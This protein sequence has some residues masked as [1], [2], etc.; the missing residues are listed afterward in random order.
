M[1]AD[2][3]A[4][5]DDGAQRDDLAAIR[6]N[7]G[8]VA[9][10]GQDLG[11]ARV[12]VNLHA[13]LARELLQRDRH[14]ARATHRI[15]DALVG[16]HVRDAAEHGRRTVRRR[17]DVLREVIHHL[18]HARIRRERAHRSRDAAPHAHGKH[19]AEHLGIEGGFEI[20]HV[21]QATNGL[22][23]EETLRD[24]VQP[25]A[26]LEEV[27]VTLAG[28]F[29]GRKTLE[30]S[31]HLFRLL[32]QVQHRAILK[33]AAPLRV[34]PDHVE[35]ILHAT[36]GLGEDAAQ[37]R[38]NRHNGRAHVEAEAVALELRSLATEPFVSFEEDDLVAASGE[39]AGGG[40]SAESATD[41]A[42]AMLRRSFHGVGWGF[43]S[44]VSCELG[45]G[46]P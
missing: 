39:R 7:A 42:D 19:V 8:D 23:E 18:R 13:K 28:I 34:E 22:V 17:A 45:L 38:R 41:D 4:V 9:T 43:E 33:E 15:P 31:A 37:H 30:F 40:E 14:G 29:A 36:T 35:V 21:A 2:G 25:L 26:E 10:F 46:R 24:V 5:R 3:I 44:L 11:D 20:E 12:C 27:E 6:A 32:L 16:L 1:G